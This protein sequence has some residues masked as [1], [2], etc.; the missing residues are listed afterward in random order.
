MRRENIENRD[1]PSISYDA[2]DSQ[3]IL[4]AAQRLVGL[5]LGDVQALIGSRVSDAR[6]KGLVGAAYESYFGLKP[7]SSWEPDFRLAGLELKS[8]PMKS[9]A[10]GYRVKE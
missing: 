7:N 4:R 10:T 8:V 6:T 1:M 9:T 2:T 3:S 5:S